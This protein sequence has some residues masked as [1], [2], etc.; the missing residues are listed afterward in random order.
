MG[1][2]NLATP[3]SAAML[4]QEACGA[5]APVELSV[6]IPGNQ[7]RNIQPLLAALDHALAGTVWEAILLN[8]DSAAK[9]SVS[10]Q[11]LTGKSRVRVVD[12]S[13]GVIS[14]QSLENLLAICAPYVAIVNCEVHPNESTL[15]EMFERIK[16]E[17]FDIVVASRSGAAANVNGHGQNGRPRKLLLAPVRRLL[18]NCDVSDAA[19]DLFLVR[20]DYLREIAPRL[21]GTGNKPLIAFLAGC[22]RPV[23]IAEIPRDCQ[24]RARGKREVDFNAALEYL[25]IV[26]DKLTLGRFP[27]R[28][29]LFLLVGALGTLIHLS[30][31]G[32]LYGRAHVGFTFSQTAATVVAMTMNFLLNNVLTF[33]DRRLRRW[34]LLT[35]LLAFY[36]VCAAGIVINVGTARFLFRLTAPWYLAALGG[37]AL[38]SAWNYGAY[39][40]IVWRA[41]SKRA[42]AAKTWDVSEVEA[43]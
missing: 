13:G 11:I 22:T 4:Q 17:Q 37:M 43:G 31:L 26:I 19:S 38:G 2:E 34:K 18:C 42:S 28:F 14:S 35:G 23:R 24:T 40:L 25:L 10:R 8:D 39:T 41:R 30:V 36:G 3:D 9:T 33:K 6:L 29:I 15:P 12:A 27:T 7:L 21:K 5:P 1:P 16:R 20:Q 32:F